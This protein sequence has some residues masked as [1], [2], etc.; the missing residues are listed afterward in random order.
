MSNTL[1]GETKV[2]RPRTGPIFAV[3]G[4]ISLGPIRDAKPKRKDSHPRGPVGRHRN[5][6]AMKKL[7]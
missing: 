6:T 1:G 4:Q 7:S 2:A 3:V 5:R